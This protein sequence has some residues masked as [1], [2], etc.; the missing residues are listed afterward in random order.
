MI[1]NF[2]KNILGSI[3]GAGLLASVVG[4]AQ[5]AKADGFLVKA[6][7]G[8]GGGFLGF[9]YGGGVGIGYQGVDWRF[10]TNVDAHVLATGIFS[11]PL[12]LEFSYMI[13]EDFVF[14]PGM[15]MG[16]GIVYLSAEK[17]SEYINFITESANSLLAG[18]PPPIKKL[19]N[20]TPVPLVEAYL[21]PKLGLEWHLGQNITLAADI[22]GYIILPV[23]FLSYGMV[24]MS[25]QFSF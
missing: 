21:T 6:E 25:G 18:G 5:V 12:T 22:K 13:G 19:N 1:N 23:V 2:Y 24:N 3:V 9:S 20:G 7:G 14:A 15:G 4:T 10:L 11:V 16:V 17:S 8:F